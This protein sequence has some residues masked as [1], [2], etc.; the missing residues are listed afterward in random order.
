MDRFRYSHNHGKWFKGNTHTHTTVSDGGKN[1]AELAEIYAAEG[2]AFLFRT[3]HWLCPEN[4]VDQANSP[5]LWIDGIELDG[6]NP[7]GYMYHVIGLG[8]FNGIHPEMKLVEAMEKIRQQDGLLI[9]AHPLWSGNRQ[10][11]ILR[12]KFDGVEVYNHVCEWLN[13]KGWGVAHWHAMLDDNPN[14]LA[15][16][17]D[18]THLRVTEPGW[19]GGWIM[20]NAAECTPQAILRAIRQGK[21]YSTQG[22]LFEQ[23]AY[24]D[25]QVHVQTSP[26]QFIRLVGPAWNGTRVGSFDGKL[27]TQAAFTVPQDWEYAYLEI[28]DS[29]GRHAWTNTLWVCGSNQ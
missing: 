4:V 15:F 20:V 14:S 9:L 6:E 16:A 3:D 8:K 7:F 19:K 2:Y 23:I 25:G 11:E 10:D 24:Q 5:L 21:F 29:C 1:F 13:G 28:E 26:V 22:P 17:A 12:W 18:D 27:F